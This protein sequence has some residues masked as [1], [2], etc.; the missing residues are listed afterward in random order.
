M[1]HPKII[2]RILGLL[3]IIEAAF[4]L[5]RLAVAFYY[6][7]TIIY[8]YLYTLATMVG[9]G[10]VLAYIG[11]GKARNISRKDGYIVVTFC[12]I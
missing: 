5:T 11:R 1:F 2:S 4:L 8:T 9:T 12:W 6:H 7:E 3:H 10:A